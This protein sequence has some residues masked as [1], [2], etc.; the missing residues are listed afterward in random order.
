DTVVGV[1][2]KVGKNG[3]EQ[4]IEIKLLPEEAAALKKSAED[5]KGNIAKVKF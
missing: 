4:I 3:M 2:V 1:P 5:V